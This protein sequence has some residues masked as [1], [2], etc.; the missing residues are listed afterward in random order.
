MLIELGYQF[1]IH[2]CSDNYLGN[3]GLIR[4]DV[5]SFCPNERVCAISY[6]ALCPDVT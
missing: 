4:P 2:V 1:Y 5:H 3:I 6:V